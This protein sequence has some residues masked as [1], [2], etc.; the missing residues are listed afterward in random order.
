M[1]EVTHGALPAGLHQLEPRGGPPRALEPR[2]L[3]GLALFG[4]KLFALKPFYRDDAGVHVME[5]WRFAEAVVHGRRSEIRT[6]LAP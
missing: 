2:H 1:S 3:Y 4:D 5:G 6:F